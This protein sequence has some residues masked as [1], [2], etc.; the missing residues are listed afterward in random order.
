[1]NVIVNKKH[2]G[3]VYKDDIYKDIN[4]GD[5]LKGIV[6]KIRKDNKLDISLTQIGYRSIEPNA[7]LILDAL[8]DNSGFIPLHDKSSPEAIKQELQMSKKAFKK[9]IGALY[10]AR[11]IE[12]KPEGICLK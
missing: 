2:L 6:K 5:K 12:I 11:K 8:N 7:Q 1:M 10:K 4:I 9:A 3:L